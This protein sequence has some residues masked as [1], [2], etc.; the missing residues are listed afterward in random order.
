MCCGAQFVVVGRLSTGVLRTTGVRFTIKL[1]QKAFQQSVVSLHMRYKEDIVDIR[2]TLFLNNAL[3][4]GAKC[5]NQSGYR[6]AEKG[7]GE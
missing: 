7:I 2:S 1:M 6:S 5:T 4:F 3:Y